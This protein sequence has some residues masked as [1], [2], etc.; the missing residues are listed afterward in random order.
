MRRQRIAAILLIALG[1]ALAAPGCGKTSK[2]PSASPAENAQSDSKSKSGSKE[3]SSGSAA[4]AVDPQKEIELARA[5]LAKKPQDPDALFRMGQAFQSG[6]QPDSAAAQFA[7]ILEQDSTNVKA[8]VHHGLAM[9]ELNR[10]DAAEAE[11]RKAIEMAPKDPLP[12]INLGSLLYFHAKKPYEAKEALTKAIEID[13]KNADAHFNLG[14]MF[15]DANL[16]HEAKVEWEEVL[17][18]GDDGPAAALARENLER[19]EP[20]FKDQAAKDQSAKQD[21]T[22]ASAQ[23][24]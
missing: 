5:E 12:Y 3:K 21:S 1:A 8:L 24:P 7:K 18:I 22:S 10:H 9:E 16:Y 20:L 6:N 15:A 13:P 14:V 2:S 17:K 23:H 4:E 11:Y 19:I